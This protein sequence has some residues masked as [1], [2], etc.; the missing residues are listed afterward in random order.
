MKPTMNYAVICYGE[1]TR[2]VATIDDLTL[3]E[4]AVRY[5]VDNKWFYPPTGTY[6]VTIVPE[7]NSS[8]HL[9]TYHVQ[10]HG[11]DYD[12]NVVYAVIAELPHFTK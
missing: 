2:V 12:N 7:S 3:V 4:V 6:Q 10:Q 11:E 5:D 1:E 9:I 8:M